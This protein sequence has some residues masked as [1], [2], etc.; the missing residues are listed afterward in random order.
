MVHKI[1]PLYIKVTLNTGGGG[2]GC[3]HKIDHI[4]LVKYLC[5]N[6]CRAAAFDATG[7]KISANVWLAASLVI[8]EVFSHVIL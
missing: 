2:G 8:V 4:L 3:I 7:S 5:A 6:P 1:D